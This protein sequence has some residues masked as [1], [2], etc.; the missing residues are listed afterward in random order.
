MCCS[1]LMSDALMAFASVDPQPKDVL[2]ERGGRAWRGPP[3]SGGPP[4]APAEGGPKIL[5]LKSSWHRRRR[6]KILAVS[7]KHWKGS[8]GGEERGVQRGGGGGLLLRCTAL[9]I[10]HCPQPNRHRADP[11]NFIGALAAA[12]CVQPPSSILK[13][14]AGARR[15]CRRGM[16]LCTFPARPRRR[17]C[18]WKQSKGGDNRAGP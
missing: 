6:S 3:S 12:V 10:H 16:Y 9:L 11:L 2:E 1:L 13:P 5:R 4:M 18:R 17:R 8:K 15:R 14:P 7:L